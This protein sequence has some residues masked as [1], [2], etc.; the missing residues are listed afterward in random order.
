MWLLKDASD[1]PI[2]LLTLLRTGVENNNLSKF[3]L[4]LFLCQ[5][6]KKLES[7]SIS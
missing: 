3:L 4:S 2:D 7:T 5:I 6:D 1:I